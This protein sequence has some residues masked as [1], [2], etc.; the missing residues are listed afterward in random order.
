MDGDCLLQ[1]NAVDRFGFTPLE[2]AVRG[3]HKEL[4]RLLKSHGAKVMQ[5]RAPLS[6]L[7]L[8]S[9]SSYLI[10]FETDATAA[11]QHPP[12][13]A[14]S[15]CLTFLLDRNLAFA[16]TPPL[17]GC[18]FLCSR[19]VA[20]PARQRGELLQLEESALSGYV[21]LNAPETEGP[22]MDWEIAKSEVTFA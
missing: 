21:V 20:A 17:V 10:Q 19:V 11:V 6:P 22:E 18:A 14:P 9:S 8:P 3:K 16:W 4:V 12:P 7:F 5:A 15:M 2:S 1:V 13:P